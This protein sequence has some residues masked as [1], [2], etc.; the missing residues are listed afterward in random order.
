MVFDSKTTRVSKL[1]AIHTLLSP[2]QVVKPSP[3]ETQQRDEDGEYW[4]SAKQTPASEHRWVSGDLSIRC[5]VYW[6]KQEC[7]WFKPTMQMYLADCIFPDIE[8]QLAAYKSFCELWDSGE[9]A[10]AD[11]FPGFEMLFR[12]HAP[13]AGR[14][15][16]LFKA[17]SDAQI[18]EHFAPWRAQYGIEM[19]FTPVIG[20]Q[21]VVDH[22]K[23]LF[24]KMS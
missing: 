14:V 7:L 10:K 13:G 21:D 24:A 6:L 18:F 2:I 16:C 23:K 15:T 12:V 8:G 5:N 3:A 20:C 22:H 1:G 17:E 9:M 19:D 4:I 11:N